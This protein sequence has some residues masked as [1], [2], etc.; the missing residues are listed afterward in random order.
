[1][2]NLEEFWE[3]TLL[4]LLIELSLGF[5]RDPS[6][7]STILSFSRGTAPSQF[8]PLSIILDYSLTAR[9][10]NLLGRLDVTFKVHHASQGQVVGALVYTCTYLLECQ[11]E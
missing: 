11:G 2:Q 10:A 3:M 1:M 5:A 8:A 6:G 7:S 4:A 9:L